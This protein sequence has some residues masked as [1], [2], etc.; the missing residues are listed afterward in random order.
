M[1][2]VIPRGEWMFL[3]GFLWI[4]TSLYMVSWATGF[5]TIHLYLPICSQ[6][7]LGRVMFASE[8]LRR[9]PLWIQRC[10]GSGKAVEVH[11][12]STLE[13]SSADRTPLKL[14]GSLLSR[15]LS[16]PSAETRQETWSYGSD[17]LVGGSEPPTRRC[18]TLHR[19]WTPR[20]TLGKASV[21]T[22][23]TIIIM[24]FVM[25]HLLWASTYYG[26]HLCHNKIGTG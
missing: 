13:P 21:P 9:E 20:R 11:F 16:G 22:T 25:K 6:V 5:S 8:T 18:P 23:M 19:E 3:P 15:T 12:I 14:L 10:L 1:E 24:S 2:S 4:L 7:R 17:V 26:S